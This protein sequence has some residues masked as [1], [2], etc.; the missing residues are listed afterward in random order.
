MLVVMTATSAVTGSRADSP[1]PLATTASAP[2]VPPKYY[3]E[4]KSY[5]GHQWGEALLTFK[6]LNITP[7]AVNAAY[8]DGK[9]VSVDFKCVPVG[10]QPCDLYSTLDSVRQKTHGRG[11]YLV[12]QY[13]VSDQGFRVAG[14]ALFY[15]VTYFFC[16]RWDDVQHH[17][18]AKVAERMRYC[19][20]RLNFESESK[21][22]L[23]SLP[24][25]QVTQY[26]MI[27]RHLLLTYGKPHDFPS[28]ALV[29]VQ[30]HPE[31][32]EPAALRDFAR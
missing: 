17:A 22:A 23:V 11:F 2:K 31:D 20:V 16:A 12:A 7:L 27:I 10:D 8:A 25:T 29:I 19:G 28:R 3:Q 26:E 21:D 24:K 14:G 4:P 15:P 6:R 32:S 18:P 30:E 13:Q 1:G 9:P 5:A